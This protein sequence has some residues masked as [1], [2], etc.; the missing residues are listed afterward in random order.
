MAWPAALGGS[1]LVRVAARVETGRA[2]PAR[3]D[4]RAG[5]TVGVPVRPARDRPGDQLMVRVSPF[6]VTVLPAS[7]LGAGPVFTEPSVIEYWLP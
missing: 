6:T 2:G 7:G 4:R 1:R 5:R 3:K